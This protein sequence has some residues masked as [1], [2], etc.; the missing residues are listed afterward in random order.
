MCGTNNNKQWKDAEVT[1]K[2]YYD[3]SGTWTVEEMAEKFSCLFREPSRFQ[4]HC[5]KLGW[6]SMR[7]CYAMIRPWWPYACGGGGGSRTLELR[8][9]PWSSLYSQNE[10][11]WGRA[12]SLPPPK[13]SN[14][15]KGDWETNTAKKIAAG[16]DAL[17]FIVLKSGIRT[18]HI[19]SLDHDLA[20]DILCK[21]LIHTPNKI[22]HFEFQQFGRW[23]NA[24]NRKRRHIHLC[25][26]LLQQ[27]VRPYPNIMVEGLNDYVQ[28]DIFRFLQ[29][30]KSAT[31]LCDLDLQQ[32]RFIDNRHRER[33]IRH[34]GRY[35]VNSLPG[36]VQGAHLH[37]LIRALEAPGC[38]IKK[39][40]L[41]GILLT[42]NSAIL[43]ASTM[44]S[45]KGLENLG[46]CGTGLT[47][48]ILVTL[49]QLGLSADNKTLLEL[50]VSWNPFTPKVMK[51]CCESLVSNTTLNVMKAEHCGIDLA[52]ITTLSSRFPDIRGL[53]HLHLDGNEFASTP[54]VE[55]ASGVVKP[56]LSNGTDN[57]VESQGAVCLVTALERNQSLWSI[58]MGEY[59]RVPRSCCTPPTYT[60][61][62]SLI[63]RYQLKNCLQRNIQLHKEKKWSQ[64]KQA[65]V[66]LAALLLYK[67]NQQEHPN[68][69]KET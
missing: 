56:T 9:R 1:L 16:F 36:D 53:R 27:S 50:N 41:G 42:K 38:P 46:L 47:E 34:E 37:P 33:P 43:L 35:M 51:A 17:C 24:P 25:A 29:S 21:H 49:F 20:A 6:D 66:R 61:R 14:A 31:S 30:I 4:V 67:I 22:T 13:N 54:L 5:L 18:L 58:R 68:C 63:T 55:P 62:I 65:V 40:N 7:G 28:P 60:D 39:I 48:N 12:G 11:V 19:K 52:Q 57:T 32:N 2:W 3:E 59:G 23:G 15:L 44:S 69:L 8:Y 10:I 26:K 45:Y 64:M